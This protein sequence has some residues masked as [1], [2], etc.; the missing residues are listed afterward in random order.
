MNTSAEVITDAELVNTYASMMS[1]EPAVEVTTQAPPASEI[2]LAIGLTRNNERVQNAEIRE[3]TG[4]DEE[5]IAKAGSAAKAL[6]VVLQRGVVSIGGEP[7]SP[8]EL[9]SLST[10]DRDALLLGI[11]KI[12]FGEDVRVIVRC[13]CGNEA[14]ADL[15]LNTEV[16]EYPFNGYTSWDV[17]TKI[18]R[19]TVTLPN[20]ITQRKLAEN[21]NLTAPELS[22]IYLGG[23]IQAVDGAPVVGPTVARNLS[24]KDREYLLTEILS[25]TPGP[26][27]SEVKKTCEAC[28]KDVQIP[29]SLAELFRLWA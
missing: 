12:T 29:L 9:T 1:A 8:Q 28:G 25:N 7:V 17:P 15:D 24:I 14:E 20:G 18:G 2:T 23:C 26:R 10:G 16:P 3:L 5:A 21:A 19:V 22:T 4:A 11:R 13:R 6:D 27:L